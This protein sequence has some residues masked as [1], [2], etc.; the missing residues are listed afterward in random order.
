MIIAS[1]LALVV[2]FGFGSFDFGEMEMPGE[3][4]T[5]SQSMIPIVSFFFGFYP[6]QAL[7]TIEQ[8]ARKITKKSDGYRSFHWLPCP[9]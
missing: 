1:I 9:A 7:T 6:K 5:F 2:A 3:T 4:A 8:A